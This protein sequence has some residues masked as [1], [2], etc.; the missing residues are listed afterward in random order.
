[1]CRGQ[2]NEREGGPFSS[3]RILGGEELD[4][5]QCVEVCGALVNVF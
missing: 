2:G 1:M 4:S 5:V 3:L